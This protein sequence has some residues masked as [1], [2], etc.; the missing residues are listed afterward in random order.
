VIQ[1]FKE[2]YLTCFTILFK[3]PGGTPRSK[4]VSAVTAIAVIEGLFLAGITSWIDIFMGTR[5]LL[6][7]SNSLP[8][9]KLVILLFFLALCFANN[10]FLVTRG[11]GIKFEREFNNLKKTRKILLVTSCCGLVLATI[12][13]FLYSRFAYRRF[14]HL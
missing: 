13:F 14:F 5:F 10:R 4:A 3:I 12:A 7:D 2:L 8:S 11:H 9:S 6:S 1:F